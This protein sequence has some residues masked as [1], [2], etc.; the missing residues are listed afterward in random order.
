MIENEKINFKLESFDGT[1]EEGP[2]EVLLQLIK[3]NKMDIENVKLALL[4]EQYLDFIS[5]LNLV[6][7]EQASEF[8]EV[9]ATLIEIKSKALLPK[10]VDENE[11]EDPEALLLQRLQEYRLLK[12]SGLK[13]KEQ[14]NTDRYYRLPDDD[15]KKYRVSI[16]DMSLDMLLDAFSRIICRVHKEAESTEVKEVAREK[17]TIVEKIVMIKKALSLDKK[18]KFSKFFEGDSTKDEV[19][20]TFLAV[21]ELL[22][23]QEIKVFQNSTFEDIDIVK[24][25]K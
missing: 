3:K 9:A 2:L 11:E 23:L 7:L 8:I 18:T 22:K 16:K 14:E 13:L 4:T 20:T 5:S 6:D 25:V 10:M 17:F 15:T 19:I 12:E 21:L 1:Y 24:V